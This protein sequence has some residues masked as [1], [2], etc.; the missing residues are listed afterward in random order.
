MARDTQ[1]LLK[2]S[3]FASLSGIPRKTLIAYDHM[4]LLSPIYVEEENQYRYYSYAQLDAADFIRTLRTL[5]VSLP[6]IGSY[7]N[8]RS[9]ENFIALCE[10][11]RRQIANQ[12]R[13]LRGIDDMI[14]IFLKDTKR[15]ISLEREGPGVSLIHR[16]RVDIFAGPCFQRGEDTL[17]VYDNLPQFYRSLEEAG[18]PYGYP[19]GRLTCK[20][21]RPAGRKDAVQRFFIKLAKRERSRANGAI[22]E[23]DYVVNWARH[24]TADTAQMYE[25]MF[26]FIDEHHLRICGSAYQ[27]IPFSELQVDQEAKYLFQISIQVESTKDT[28]LS[29]PI[30]DAIPNI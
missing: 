2:I 6:A 1:G 17:K 23:G 20:N 22:P 29:L 10:S 30:K 14:G 5:D 18:F 16:E 15:A 4:G 8:S 11:Q 13:L 19:W 28:D 12:I 26:S 24:G 7:L 3:E 9:P 27:E 21:L 25:E